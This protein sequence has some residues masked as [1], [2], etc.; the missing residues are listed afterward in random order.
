MVRLIQTAK[1]AF[2]FLF[3]STYTRLAYLLTTRQFEKLQI[4]YYFV[5]KE[6]LESFFLQIHFADARS[7]S[8]S[9]P[10]Y[11]RFVSIKVGKGGKKIKTG[12]AK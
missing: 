3:S 12:K 5:K 7:L 1:L 8:G 6:N 9:I 4:S 10:K 2:V 11:A